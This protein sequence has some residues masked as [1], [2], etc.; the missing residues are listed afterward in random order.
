MQSY[1]EAWSSLFD[2]EVV[3]A[4][5]GI[6]ARLMKLETSGSY[7]GVTILK[8]LIMSPR[9]RLYASVGRFRARKRSGC[10]RFFNE[11]TSLVARRCTFSIA[12]ICFLR[13]GAHI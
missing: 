13:C 6:A 8:S 2:L 5:C 12:V 4:G 9:W 10:G 1:L 3:S 7:V 11:G